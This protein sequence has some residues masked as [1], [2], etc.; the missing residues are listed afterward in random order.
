MNKS[1]FRH[2]AKGSD[3]E[4]EMGTNIEDTLDFTS[5]NH[6]STRNGI[7]LNGKK[8][9]KYRTPIPLMKPLPENR[10]NHIQKVRIT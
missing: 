4:N 10:E 1:S 3:Y 9:P 7:T 5:F 8:S 6:D 2:N